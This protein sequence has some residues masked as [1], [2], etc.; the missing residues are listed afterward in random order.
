MFIFFLNNMIVYLQ[1]LQIVKRIKRI[2]ADGGY[3]VIAKVTAK[4]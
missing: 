2:P 4:K 3:R 1:S